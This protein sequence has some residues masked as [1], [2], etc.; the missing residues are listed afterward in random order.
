MTH[1]VNEGFNLILNLNLNQTS[2]SSNVIFSP[3][4]CCHLCVNDPFSLRLAVNAPD[5]GLLD[6][7]WAQLDVKLCLTLFSGG[8]S[9][10]NIPSN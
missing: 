1:R 6:S 4:F 8:L 2:V 7:R 5:G 3:N 10:F 9:P